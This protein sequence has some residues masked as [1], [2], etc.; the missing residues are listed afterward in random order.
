MGGAHIRH[1]TPARFHNGKFRTRRGIAHIGAHKQL[2]PATQRKTLR[3]GNDR[4]F[5]FAPG[6]CHFLRA[7]GQPVRALGQFSTLFAI[8]HAGIAAFSHSGKIAH[9]QTGTKGSSLAG[10]NNGADRFIGFNALATFN[11]RVHHLSVQRIHFVTANE[12]RMCNMVLNLQIN[13][14]FHLYLL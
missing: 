12:M 3:G 9:I 13:T 6:K 5:D 11:Q 4:H 8:G 14:I 2:K 7:I 1:Q 10:K